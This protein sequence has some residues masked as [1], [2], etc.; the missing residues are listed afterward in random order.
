MQK[1]VRVRGRAFPFGESVVGAQRTDRTQRTSQAMSWNGSDGTAAG[2][3]PIARRGLSPAN[4]R[5]TADARRVGARLAIALA[6]ALAGAGVWWWATRTRLAAVPPPSA[7]LPRPP[8][9]LS[10]E[11]SPSPAGPVPAPTAPK[12][13]RRRVAGVEVVATLGAETNRD[14]AVVER[15][16]LADGRRVRAVT[17]P[18]PVFRHPSD[19]LIAMALSAKP[20][21][22]APPLPLG[23]DVERDFLASLDE[24]IET[25]ASD[26]DEIRELK[27]RVR[28]AREAI[29]EEVRAGKSVRQVLEE[30]QREQEH[31]TECRLMAARETQEIR[32]TAGEAAAR[33]FAARANESLR[34]GGVPEIPVHNEETARQAEGEGEIE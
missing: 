18:P 31:M 26:T 20:G 7:T 34:A 8:K 9:V 30:H 28:A 29:A 24:P 1:P 19:Q 12:A 21:E 2:G 3:P 4:A 23:P 14:G 16:V 33:A 10:P 5:R 25:L 22:A 27:R 17:L 11:S 6:A 13:E 15:L 32:A